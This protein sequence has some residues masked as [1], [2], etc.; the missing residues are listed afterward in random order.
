MVGGH[1]GIAVNFRIIEITTNMTAC[2]EAK[3]LSFMKKLL[4]PTP[5]KKTD[6]VLTSTCR[7]TASYLRI[8]HTRLTSAV[9]QLNTL[10][11]STCIPCVRVLDT[12]GPCQLLVHSL[13]VKIGMYLC[14]T[15]DGARGT[16]VAREGCVT[17]S[18][19]PRPKLLGHMALGQAYYCT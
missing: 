18:A 12:A 5:I 4:R 11:V 16:S 9:N 2:K 14:T 8:P 19:R 13:W 17:L 7:A 15:G 1:S 6:F 10:V 3:D